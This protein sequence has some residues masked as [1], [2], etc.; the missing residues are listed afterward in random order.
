MVMIK[1]LESRCYSLQ[2]V[3]F[4]KVCE[5]FVIIGKYQVIG[6]GIVTMVRLTSLCSFQ[7]E[8]ELAEDSVFSKHTLLDSLQ[9]GSRWSESIELC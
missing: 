6:Q 8:L 2:E 7:L 1:W 5:S 3:P 4:N 9:L